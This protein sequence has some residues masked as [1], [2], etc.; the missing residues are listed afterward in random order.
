MRNCPEEIANVLLISGSQDKLSWRNFILAKTLE[1]SFIWNNCLQWSLAWW[2]I[3]ISDMNEATL[4]AEFLQDSMSWYT[5][6][7]MIPNSPYVIL[8]LLLTYATKYLYTTT[9]CI[10]DYRI[11][12]CWCT[13]LQCSAVLLWHV[14]QGRCLSTRTCIIW[15]RY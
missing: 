11:S 6:S 8:M 13:Q 3:S 4:M 14:E 5:A 15:K 12:Q 10:N 2:S 7:H 1:S 9:R